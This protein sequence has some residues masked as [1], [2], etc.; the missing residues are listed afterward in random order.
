MEIFKFQYAVVSGNIYG[1]IIPVIN[2][3]IDTITMDRNPNT[4]KK[5][6]LSKIYVNS[7]FTYFYLKSYL[8]MSPFFDIF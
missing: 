7:L 1:T 8:K 3:Q 5:L 2:A 4:I 6:D